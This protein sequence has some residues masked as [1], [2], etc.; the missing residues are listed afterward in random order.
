M[1]VVS[2]ADPGSTLP[3]VDLTG[4]AEK[5]PYQEF[6]QR[7]GSSEA[8]MRKAYS[9]VKDQFRE[10]FERELAD[11]VAN[12]EELRDE[13]IYLLAAYANRGA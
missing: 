12:E 3:L 4:L 9:R 2:L 7:H 10:A 5:P 11:T 6:A 8:T 1:Q 13:I